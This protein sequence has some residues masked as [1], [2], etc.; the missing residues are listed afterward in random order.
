MATYTNTEVFQ[1]D[2]F[3]TGTDEVFPRL[4]ERAA[5]I[6]YHYINSALGG[7]YAVPFTDPAPGS[8][9]SISDMLTK[10][11]VL[12][13]QSRRSPILPKMNNKERMDG[14]CARA[15]EWLQAL[16]RQ[17]MTMPEVAPLPGTGAVAMPGDFH[18]IFDVDDSLNHLPD[19]DLLDKIERERD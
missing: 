15:V 4:L 19:P 3:P 12:Q 7:T 10:C 6:A 11:F 14:D 9:V 13:L 17:E 8:I 1:R 18:P 2:F 5:E 16:R